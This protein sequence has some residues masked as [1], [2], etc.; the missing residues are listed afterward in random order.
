[1]HHFPL[2][3]A[4]FCFPSQLRNTQYIMEDF[5]VFTILD[6]LFSYM[7]EDGPAAKTHATENLFFF[8]K[9]SMFKREKNIS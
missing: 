6:F 4:I 9:K 3:S 1:M 5:V 8:L 7:N 2:K